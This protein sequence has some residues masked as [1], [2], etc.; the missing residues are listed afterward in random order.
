MTLAAVH[1]AADACSSGE[2][3]RV[4]PARIFECSFTARSSPCID[5]ILDDNGYLG[6]CP[7]GCYPEFW[8][9]IYPQRHWKLSLTAISTTWRLLFRSME[10]ATRTAII[11]PCDIMAIQHTLAYQKAGVAK[12]CRFSIEYFR[13]PSLPHG[14]RSDDD[15]EFVRFR[16]VTE[17]CCEMH[18]Q[19]GRI[20][21]VWV[22]YC[23][24]AALADRPRHCQNHRRD[25]ATECSSGTERTARSDL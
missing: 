9:N 7:D 5:G 18:C 17:A 1:R 6:R 20:H 15:T 10:V 23:F 4:Q 21:A 22:L 3:R 12:C 25:R 13:T 14:R 16:G 24:L 8:K 2:M 19:C 11:L